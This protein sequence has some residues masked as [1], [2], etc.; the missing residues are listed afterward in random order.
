M[1]LASQ[2]LYGRLGL[3]VAGGVVCVLL[4]WFQ[5][6]AP[7]DNM[8][9]DTANEAI[10]LPL[11]DDILI[12]AVDERSLLELGRWPWPRERH[13]ELLR[14]LR[15]AGAGAIAMDIVFAEPDTEYPQVDRLLGE[16]I[17]RYG[18]VVLPVFVGQADRG[19]QLLEIEP[20]AP[21]ASSAARLGHVHIEVDADGV[22]R[23]VFL[24]EGLVT[25]HWEHFT[26][27]L[28]RLLGLQ[29]DPLPGLSEQRVTAQPSV[30][31]I[32][33]SHENLLPFMGRAGTVDMVSYVDVIKS[34]IPGRILQNKVIF[35]GATAA[36]HA[37]NISTSHGQ[38][39]GVE[40]NANIFHALR[41]DKLAQRVSPEINALLAFVITFSTII[42]FTRLEPRAL[43]A[44][45]LLS[46][47]FVLLGSLALLKWL[48]VWFSPAPVVLTILLAYPLWNW[49]RLDA[50]VDFMHEQL[51][52]LESE[53]RKSDFGWDWHHLESAATFLQALGRVTRWRIDK[54]GQEPVPA[55]DERE[56][57][58]EPGAS[59]KWF[60]IDGER[61]LLT[62]HWSANHSAEKDDLNLVFPEIDDDKITPVFGGDFID[63]D[64]EQLELAYRQARHNRELVSSTLAQ[65]SNGV[66]LAD[67]SGTILLLNEQA[68]HLLALHRSS[69]TLLEALQRLEFSAS[70]D[71]CD[72]L[73]SLAL[74]GIAFNEEGRTLDGGRDVLCR[75]RLIRLDRPM[76]LVSLTDVTDLKSSEK[77][78]GEALNFLS[79]DLRAPLTSVLAL[80][81]GARSE[82]PD[83]LNLKLLKN[84]ERYVRNNL[85]YAENY[86]QLA[87]LEHTELAAMDECDGQSL[88][89]NAVSLVFHAASARAIKFSLSICEEDVWISCNRSVLERAILNLLDN[90][91]KYSA[92][93]STITVALSRDTTSAIIQVTDRGSGIAPADVERI[94]DS[95]QQGSSPVS[96][97]GLGLRFVAA[98]AQSHQGSI[99]VD[100]APDKGT[101]FTLKIPR[102]VSE[103]AT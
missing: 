89:D 102:L 20:I 83:Q 63:V 47:L 1:R 33:R 61:G 2:I 32:A 95:F 25:P 70:I 77:R 51:R 66:I 14:R 69:G 50:A 18:A 103:A 98:A 56:W 78:R 73:G 90:A 15:D 42:L 31:S 43:L 71:I 99:S 91:L 34:R 45:V 5:L 94:F 93:G 26:V 97:V 21:L 46:A 3:A 9:Y 53:N 58:H 88:I 36:G 13:V 96:G 79:H 84:I 44:A 29:V 7:L 10:P 72:L 80:I 62:L 86:T 40:I 8:V 101:T 11:A 35:V 75:G 64:I 52:L 57:N 38:I 6:I 49:L 60:S 17:A 39:S 48:Q 24:K 27:A 22:A 74:Q 4:G 81:E 68:R 82:H 65:L 23:S 12:V 41:S 85:A 30:V 59:K 54:Y 92:D 55:A 28:S 67:S 76:L 100:S 16:E 87:R 37:D 19:G